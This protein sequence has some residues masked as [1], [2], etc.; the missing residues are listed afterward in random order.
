MIPGNHW[1]EQDRYDN[2][3]GR[4]KGGGVGP[5][6]RCTPSLTNKSSAKPQAINL[7]TQ[8]SRL[9]TYQATKLLASLR[10]SQIDDLAQN[11]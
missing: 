7:E 5:T 1:S 6:K 11:I 3:C 2:S 8:C 9:G 4:L 10:I